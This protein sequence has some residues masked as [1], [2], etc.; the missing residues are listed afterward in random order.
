[1]GFKEYIW[2]HLKQYVGLNIKK[3]WSLLADV[4]TPQRKTLA[5]FMLLTV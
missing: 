5:P 1:M 4:A 3:L 2:K